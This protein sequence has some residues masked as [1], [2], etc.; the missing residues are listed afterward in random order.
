MTLLLLASA[1]A[2]GAT[3]QAQ[4]KVQVMVVGTYHMANP[5]ADLIKTE[6]DDHTSPKRQK[7]IQ[8]L[9]D[10]LA[11]FKPTKIMVERMPEDGANEKYH[12]YL[13]D[14]YTLTVNEIDQV[15]MRLARKMGNKDIYPIDYRTGMD[16]DPLFAFAKNANDTEF[17]SYF[18]ATK[19]EVE[20]MLNGLRDHTVE[21]NLSMMNSPEQLHL[22]MEFYVRTLRL[23]DGKDYPGADMLAGWYSRNLRIFGNLAKVVQP[24]DKVIVLFGQGHAP[25]L[26]QLVI[27]SGNM[28]LVEPSAYLGNP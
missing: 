10:D 11:K 2:L 8:D 25:I 27:D 19:A 21:Q 7:E 18:E 4:P 22:A 12:S 5:K 24:G 23:N 26:R 13:E 16:F 20:K 6:L 28:D 15:G 1:V 17:F 3:L 9:V 14:K